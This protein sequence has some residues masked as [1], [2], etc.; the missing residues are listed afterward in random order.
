MEELHDVYQHFQLYYSTDIPKMKAALKLKK[1]KERQEASEE[2]EREEP[3]EEE[4]L[5]QATRKTGYNLCVDAGLVELARKFGLSPEQ[6]GENLRDNYQRH[7]VEQDPTEPDT[8]AAE[9]MNKQFATAQDVL[10]GARHVVA[11]QLAH[12]PVTH[13]CVRQTF[14]ERA[15]ITAKPT[16]KGVKEIDEGHVCYTFKYIKNKPVQDFCEDQ[17]LK[18]TQAVDDGL[19]TYEIH[20]DERDNARCT[21]YFDEIKQLYHRDEFSN[22]VQEWNTQRSMALEKA[23]TQVLFPLLIKEVKSKLLDEAKESIIRASCRKLYNWLKVAP[24]A[25]DQPLEDEDEEFDTS[26]GVRVMGVVYSSKRDEASFSAIVDGDGEVVD[27]LRLPHITKRK[28]GWNAEEREQKEGDLQRVKSFI[29]AKKPHVI[30]VGAD[31]RE[32]LRIIEDLKAIVTEL[33]QE[34]NIVP[35]NVELIDLELACVYANS[36]K[37]ENEM[38]EYPLLLRQAVSLA[39]RLQDPLIEFSQ[40]CNVD[41]DIICLRYHTLQESVNKDD[42]LEALYLEFVNRVNEVGVDVNRCIAH[43]HTASLIQFVCGLGSRKG[44]H[45]LKTLKQNNTPLENRTQL[46]THPHVRMGPKVFLNCSGF[47]KINTSALADSTEQYVEVLD[48][49]RIHPE[50]YEWARKMAVDA[51]EYDDTAEDA[52]PAGALEEILE[53]PE[54][55]KDLDLDAFAEE[56]QRQGYGDK[57]ITLY[58]IRA[59]L[60][61]RYKDLRTPYRSCPVEERFNLLTK[62]TPQ[63]FYIGKL[64]TCQV[65]GIAHRRPQ[66]DQLEVAHPVRNDETGLWQCPFCQKNNFPELSEVWNHFDAGGCP[67]QAVGVKTRLDNSVS[68][69]IPL[70]NLSDKHVTNPAE[71]VKVN[72]MLHS[73]ITKIHIDRFQVELTTK[74]SDLIDA[75][76]KWKLQKDTY[77]DYD[78]EDV[79]KRKE[80]DK[81]KQQARQTYVKR[82]IAHPS[83]HNIDY[84]MC[85]KLM[86]NMDQGDIIIRPSSKSSDH[87]TVTWKVAGTILQHIDV[88]EEHKENSFSIG[89]CLH[90]NNESFEDLDEII[91]RH[92]Q[93]MAAFARDL[94]NYKSYRDMEGSNSMEAV[95]RLLT[96]EKRK[97]PSKIPYFFTASEKSP[98]KFLLSYFPRRTCKHEFV[99]VTPEGMR[100][101]S[102]MFHSLVALIRWFKEHFRDLVPGTPVGQRTPM[103]T[104]GPDMHSG[105]P[106]SHHRSAGVQFNAM[107][108]GFPQKSG[109]GAGNTTPFGQYPAGMATPLMTPGM[110]PAHHQMSTPG[111]RMAP[112]PMGRPSMSA[113]TPQYQMTPRHYPPPTT[114]VTQSPR[115]P[116]WAGT[117]HPPE[118]S[119]TPRSQARDSAN[120]DWAKRAELWAK[121]KALEQMQAGTSRGTPRRTPRQSPYCTPVGDQTPL[122]DEDR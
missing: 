27:Y 33:E 56:L 71:R 42:L 13:A 106:S 77:Y 103:G 31:S 26:H 21:E 45:L 28:M 1:K 119:Q 69:F 7:E 70:R 32:A 75:D 36:K 57:H 73:R 8:L 12:D 48:G 9:F 2:Q 20:I 46:V 98:G 5:K 100:Y 62:E 11:M 64:I 82:V 16:K 83:F 84:K 89:K 113:H 72:M 104:P 65:T 87:L 95:E 38:R 115:P 110:T 76:N 120:M 105:E 25:I 94:I 80:E 54:R 114:P 29:L 15:K 40:L 112:P 4:T 118:A 59:E 37:S 99:T 19:M 122:V 97:Q 34:H 17:F 111:Q 61:H 66:G 67:G 24:Y 58:D 41:E 91:A 81:K 74:S 102:H 92:V 10:S 47:I 90:I 86:L 117:R 78:L 107:S 35:I 79:D 93:P 44:N 53:S 14:F 18:L 43:P 63:T 3:E 68:G 30:A 109:F 60:N 121:S 51:L 52:N 116:Q 23:L 96:D 22:L 88:R 39:R 108:Q 49:S 85:E 6:F 50:T 101:R 55:L